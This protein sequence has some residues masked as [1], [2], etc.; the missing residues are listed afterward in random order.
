MVGLG[1]RVDEGSR[2]I[3]LEKCSTYNLGRLP[4]HNSEASNEAAIVHRG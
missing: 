1:V 3:L 4:A 2:T